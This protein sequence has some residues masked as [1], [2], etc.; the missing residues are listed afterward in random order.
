MEVALV[1]KFCGSFETDEELAETREK[2]LLVE[3]V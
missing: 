3:I 2:E 1:E